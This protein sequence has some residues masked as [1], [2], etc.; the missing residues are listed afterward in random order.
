M[1]EPDGSSEISDFDAEPSLE[2]VRQ[3]P[4]EL[5]SP[6]HTV[7]LLDHDSQVLLFLFDF[8]S[9]EGFRAS[10]SSSVGDALDHLAKWHPEI[11]IANMEMPEGT[12]SELLARV[13]MMAPSTRIIL[14]SD[15]AVRA[16]VL[17]VLRGQGLDWIAKPIEGTRLRSVLERVLAR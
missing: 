6:V 5:D 4:P 15:R 3:V 7:H 2:L 10:A 9:E 11:L 16:D 14:T 13:K 8:L 1:P 17:K 12:A